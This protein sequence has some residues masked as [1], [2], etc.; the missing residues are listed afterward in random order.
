MV[1]SC[2]QVNAYLIDPGPK[3]WRNHPNAFDPE[4]STHADSDELFRSG[5]LE[6]PQFGQSSA[7]CYVLAF[8]EG[9]GICADN[10]TIVFIKATAIVDDQIGGK[11][12]DLL[13]SKTLSARDFQL[14]KIRVGKWSNHPLQRALRE[15]AAQRF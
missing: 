13:K 14:F 10:L 3:I 15:K 2:S 5:V 11:R 9:E 12:T 1:R 6:I 4:K 7:D 8:L